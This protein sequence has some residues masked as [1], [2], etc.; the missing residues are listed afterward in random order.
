MVTSPATYAVD[1]HAL[2]WYFAVD[3]RLSRRAAEVLRKAETGSL[4]VVLST[5]VLAEAVRVIERNRVKLRGGLMPL[6]EAMPGLRVVPFDLD[7]FREMLKLPP[8]LEI[9]DRMIAAT[10]RQYGAK[11]ITRDAELAKVVTI[12][13]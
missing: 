7:T 9:H 6:I 3:K 8:S 1:T 5:V 10:T 12:H 2:L 4:D 11:L 13:W